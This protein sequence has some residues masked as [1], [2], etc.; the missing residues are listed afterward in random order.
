M[1]WQTGMNHMNKFVFFVSSTG[2]CKYLKSLRKQGSVL[3]ALTICS[4]ENSGV[5]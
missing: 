3:V 1:C 5:I 4:M 2:T